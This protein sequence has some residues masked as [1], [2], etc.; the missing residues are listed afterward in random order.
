VAARPPAGTVVLPDADL[1]VGRVVRALDVT[2]GT[3][4]RQLP[5]HVRLGLDE[6]DALVEG[7]GVQRA[8][9]AALE[10]AGVV[11]DA[12]TSGDAGLALAVVVGLHPP[13]SADLAALVQRLAAALPGRVVQHVDPLRDP[14]LVVLV[15]EVRAQRA[16]AGRGRVGV[17]PLAA[18]AEDA[19]PARREPGQVAAEHLAL[20][21]RVLEFDPGSGKDGVDLGHRRTI[22]PGANVVVRRL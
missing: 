18:V 8:A 6:V 14:L 3:P 10:V 12:R 1:G 22:T 19:G 15:R 5:A 11:E 2:E 7:Q 17:D 20:V 21:R 13:R 9:V 4:Q 16:A